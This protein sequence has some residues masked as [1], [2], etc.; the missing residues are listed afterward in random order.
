MFTK[1]NQIQG[2][3]IIMKRNLQ[4]IYTIVFSCIICFNAADGGSKKRRGTA[5]AQELLIPVGAR[6][7]AMSNAFVAGLTGVEAAASNPA[8]VSGLDGTGQ[9]MFSHTMWLADIGVNYVAVVSKF[10]GESVFGIT[11]RTLDFGNIPVTTTEYPDGTG[12]TFSPNYVT[13][14]FLFSKQMTDRI[15]F[16]TDFKIV[17]EGIMRESATG[18]VLDAGV[19]YASS[20]GGLRLGAALKNLGM[21]M[22]FEGPDLEEFHTP[23]GSQP[24]TSSE[25]RRVQLQDFE[26]PTTLE[27]GVAYGPHA[28]GPGKVNLAASFL[29]NNF[30]FDEYRFGGEISIFDILA[31]RGGLTISHDPEPFGT[32]G[33]Q[34]TDDDADDD[35]FEYQSE[36]FIWGPTFGFGISPKT[37]TNLNVSIDYAYRTTEIFEDTQWLTIT[38]GF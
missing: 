5:G 7:I 11:A 26:M 17:E 32:D 16:G 28:L 18:F 29:N 8:G 22:N 3:N 4:I 23:E 35:K 38:L 24:G 6:N 15:R 36:E 21:N 34:G 30:S 14:G 13:L 37:S 1:K 19:Q 10:K 2:K 9:A 12:A 27:L 31:L 33:I 25:P 20:S